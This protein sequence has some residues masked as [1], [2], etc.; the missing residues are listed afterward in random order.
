MRF[1]LDVLK[2]MEADRRDPS[3]RFYDENYRYK[4]PGIIIDLDQ[5]KYDRDSTDPAVIFDEQGIPVLLENLKRRFI[6][7]NPKSGVG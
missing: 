3:Q 1:A 6:I 5:I 2:Q 4:E 7:T